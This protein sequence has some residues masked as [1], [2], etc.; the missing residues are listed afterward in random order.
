MRNHSIV[1]VKNI[2]GR[3]SYSECFKISLSGCYP[4]GC[5]Y[6]ITVNLSF[7]T[8]FQYVYVQLTTFT[9]VLRFVFRDLFCTLFQRGYVQV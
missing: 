7:C 9:I 3:A 5:N 6:R 2:Y 1:N 8:L 4:R